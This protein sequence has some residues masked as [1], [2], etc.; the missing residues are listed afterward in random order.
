MKIID[1]G[2]GWSLED[3]GVDVCIMGPGRLEIVLRDFDPKKL[4]HE[5]GLPSSILG[6]LRQISWRYP[7]ESVT[8]L[9]LISPWDS[10]AAD[11][12]HQH[13]RD[14]A[15]AVTWAL[16]GSVGERLQGWLAQAE[17]GYRT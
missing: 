4:V 1:F 5:E 10:S 17:E 14:R 2:Q 15:N 11:A 8:A 9:Q 13:S 6:T 3:D 7:L 12:P 16:S